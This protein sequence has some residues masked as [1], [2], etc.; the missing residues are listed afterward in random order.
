MDI[1]VD[2][3]TGEL[4]RDGKAI[5]LAPQPAKLIALLASRPHELVTRDEIRA[6]IWGAD[7]FV[8]F[9]RG[10]NFCVLQARTALGDDAKNP[11]YIQT[12]PKR[13]YR[14]IAT[15]AASA[16]HP[17]PRRFPRLAA[18]AL[19]PL[20]F[21]GSAQKTETRVRL[22][23]LPFASADEPFSDGMTDE[24]ITTLGAVDPQRLAVI[25]RPSVLRYRNTTKRA[26]DIAND[27]ANDL[28]VRYIVTGTM[29]RDADHVRVT[30]QLID[31]RDETNVWSEAFD[32]SS[33]GALA[34]QRDIA[35]RVAR[36]LELRLLP[37]DSGTSVPA[38]H[39]AYLRGRYLVAQRDTASVEEGLAELRR[40]VTLDP[41]FALA[42]VALAEA[43]HILA[44]R[45]VIAPA[46]ARVEI[47]RASDA[48]MA[49]APSLAQSHAT[50]A[51]LH[52]WYDWDPDAAE[53]S[54]RRAI[55]LNPS[56]VG[57]L[58]DHG[59]L[60]IV[61]GFP[62]EGI[63]QIRRAQELDPVSPRANAHVAWA[64]V[65]TGHYD[66][67]VAEARKALA[68]SPE[69]E[70]AYRC[71]EEAYVLAGNYAEAMKA[72][73]A[74][75]T[76]QHEELVHVADLQGFY[77]AERA[78]FADEALKDTR[79]AYRVAAAMAMAGRRDEAF[80]WLARAR[81]ERNTNMPLAGVDPKL[82]SLRNDPRFGGLVYHAAR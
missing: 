23:V 19:L 18:V 49:L 45:D 39:E 36:A 38:A 16:P 76:L 52:F 47:R 35:E 28:G 32:R 5:A 20:L 27:I 43:V 56:E 63:A 82:R 79:D 29:R 53:A 44:M 71:I 17:Q 15:P 80:T 77:A 22:A 14:W 75:L 69:F 37:R 68:L 1:V 48:A 46:E 50:A 30:A 4:R 55:E 59:W 7:T 66:L 24:L 33:A 40:S 2:P 60:L 64:Y 78:Q 61:R 34:I 21:L 74:R 42:H 11:R 31:A 25:A 26:N 65:Y 81:A 51:M 10:L 9:E 73:N 12:L 67:A 41:K 54:Y 57:A 70:E 3:R 62:E 58:H 13:G 72:R 6:A 8:D